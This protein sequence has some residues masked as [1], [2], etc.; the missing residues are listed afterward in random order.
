MTRSVLG[1]PETLDYQDALLGNLAWYLVTRTEGTL[2]F[3]LGSATATTAG[4]DTLTWRGCLDVANARFGAAT[5]PPY[6]LASGTDP[7]GNAYV[8]KARDYAGGLAVTR[9]RGDWY[10]GIEPAG[11]VSVPLSMPLYPVL[12]D[13]SIG[14][15]VSA[16][17]LRNGQGMLL[18]T[19]FVP[20][21]LVSSAAERTAEGA[22]LTWETAGLPTDH[23]GFHVYRENPDGARDRLTPALLTG[24]TRYR[25]VDPQPPASATRYWL[26]D[27]SRTGTVS[28]L[29]PLTLD[30]ARPGPV[31]LQLA[32][33][34]PNPFRSGTQI[35]FTLPAEGSAR[36]RVHDV[37]GR[38]VAT[39]LDGTLPAGDHTVSWDGR[40]PRGVP[41]APGVYFYVLDTPRGR[42][43]REMIRLP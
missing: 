5:G 32:Q 17:S 4:W 13:G 38:V 39:L 3:E 28:W 41:V 12:A 24:T 1:H 42:A 26:A 7:L 11:A 31:L 8:V 29:G 22:V 30:P 19:D 27:L 21:E 33:N 16:L 14:A 9:N 36:L 15:A 37:T 35:R 20:V 23:A 18:L 2:L 10:Q 25:F 43:A 34:R 6:T 40:D